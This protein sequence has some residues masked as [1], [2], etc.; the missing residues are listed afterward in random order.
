MIFDKAVTDAP[1]ALPWSGSPNTPAIALNQIYSGR[2]S[3]A[4]IEL[5]SKEAENGY[6]LS[7][8]VRRG[9]S[10]L[11]ENRPHV[12]TRVVEWGQF[13]SPKYLGAGE[14]AIVHAEVLDGR[15]VALKI[16]APTK[17]EDPAAVRGLKREVMIMTLMDHPNVLKGLAIGYEGGRPFMV[18]D[19]LKSVLAAELPTDPNATLFFT[20]RKQLKAWPLTRAVRCA[21][22]L[23][24][25]LEYCHDA[26]FVGYRVLHRDIKPDNMGFVGDGNLV[27]FDFG[28]AALWQLKDDEMSKSDDARPL[29]GDTGSL[30]YMAPEVANS[31]RYNYKAEMF[32][33]ATVVW[34][35]CAHRKPYTDF[36]PLHMPAVLA[37]GVTPK[38]NQKWPAQLREMLSQCWEL[39]ASM[40]PDFSQ[41][42]PQLEVLHL[43]L[44]QSDTP[45]K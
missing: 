25:A 26:A 42:V 19:Q 2:A 18:L 10:A 17:R 14:F 31:M 28:L 45:K 15:P 36:L 24:K 6:D 13:A 1:P 34:E 40:R 5:S 21:L 32:S 37:R 22:D 35:M 8:C 29:T 11:L 4:P 33:F 3:R 12:D 9:S 27:L 30:R 16:L 7:T 23:A 41:I 38:L 39:E 43:E 20:R 44:L